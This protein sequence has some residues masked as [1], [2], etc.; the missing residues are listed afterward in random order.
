MGWSITRRGNQ[1]TRRRN[2]DT[3]FDRRE[4]LS[5]NAQHMSEVFKVYTH[6]VRKHFLLLAED[7]N[8]NTVKLYFRLHSM[9]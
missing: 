7:P 4:M 3:I 5:R 2:L 9:H 1:P 8:S 6:S